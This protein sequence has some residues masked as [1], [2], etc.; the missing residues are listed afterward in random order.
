MKSG[1]PPLKRCS[2]LAWWCEPSMLLLIVLPIMAYAETQPITITPL[3][4]PKTVYRGSSYK[5][6]LDFSGGNKNGPYFAEY[7]EDSYISGEWTNKIHSK[8]QIVNKEVWNKS[9]ITDKTT[10]IRVRYI[11][12]DNESNQ[13]EWISDEIPVVELPFSFQDTEIILFIGQTASFFSNDK[14]DY[15][16]MMIS[17][18][19]NIA[20]GEC[21]YS[22]MDNT[23]YYDFIYTIKAISEGTAIISLTDSYYNV[24][25]SITVIVQD[26]NAY[27]YGD[28]NADGHVDGRDLLRLA[29]YIAGQDVV[30]DKRATDVNGDGNVDGRDVLRLAKQLAGM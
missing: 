27:L 26:D 25:D 30:I 6:E 7:W 13:A 17:S 29:R 15:V 24:I 12:S 19:P 3:S 1:S 22:S 11:I 10:K 18:N 28:V 4:V 8:Y 14:T 5:V 9:I 2:L 16:P 21:S 20:R 23:E